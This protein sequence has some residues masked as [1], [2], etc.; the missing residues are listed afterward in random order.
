MHRLLFHTTLIASLVLCFHCTGQNLVPNPSFET[1][2]KCPIGISGLEYSPGYVTFPSVQSWVNPLQVASADYFNRCAPQSSGV[3]VP[4]NTFGHQTART[5][6]AY[7]GIIAWEGRTLNGSIINTYGEY[8]QCK[9]SQPM[10][11]GKS[12]CV[13][14][15]V[16]NGISTASYNFV[17]IDAMGV[18]FSNNKGTYPTGSTISMQYSIANTP[19]NFLTDTATWKRVSGIYTA[20]G[21]EEWMTMGWFDNGGVPAFQ[22]INPAIPNPN[23]QYRCYL[24]IDDVSVME[25][26]SVDTFYTSTDTTICK[27]GAFQLVLESSV[28]LAEYKWN[29]GVTTPKTSITDTGTYYCVASTGC[30]TYIDTYKVKYE[31]APTLDIGDELVNCNNQP[32]TIYANYPNSNYI[33]STGATTDSIIV[34]QPGVY[35]LTI[36]NLCGTQEDSISV[37][38][39]PPTPTPPP[40]DTMICQFETRATINIT[41][42]NITWYTHA[43]GHIG[44]LQQPPIIA[45]VPGTYSLF[46]TQTIGKCESEKVPVT[47]NVKYTP[48]EE[49]GDKVVMCENDLKIIG[50][51]HEAVTFKWNTGATACCV[52]PYKDGLYKRATENECGSF[53]DSLWVLHTPCVECIVF[54]NAFTPVKGSAN[55]IF[56]PIIKCPVAE[57]S[58]KIYN[59]WGN[60]V[61]Q[62]TNVH[63]GWNGRYNYDFA[64]LGTYVYTVEYRAKDKKQTQYIKGNVTLLR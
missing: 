54:P 49:L 52:T 22:P 57:F 2:N 36:S 38:I 11:A 29:N 21:G 24:F 23:F 56:R 30:I 44:S 53:I 5:G 41:G 28:Q 51:P 48:H 32:V 18:N 58:M 40:T 7:V 60:L 61:Y 33:W 25:M 45:K 17:G 42:E 34:D 19:G 13:T 20:H 6:N 47:I 63:D 16:N 27:P 10:I 12:Y 14:Y 46:V 50:E 43:Q 8:V 35:Y 26:T 37:Y 1:Y 62:S 4:G 31:P 15:Y 3:S 59:R 39:Q 55:N 64:P 9:L